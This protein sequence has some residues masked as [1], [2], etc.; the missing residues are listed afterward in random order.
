MFNNKGIEN[1]QGFA[2]ERQEV[3]ENINTFMIGIQGVGNISKIAFI[4][5]NK[6]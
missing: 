6:Y 2:W 1:G 5:Q 4:S 3:Q